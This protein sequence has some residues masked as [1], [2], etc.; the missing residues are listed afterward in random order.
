MSPQVITGPVEPEQPETFQ[1]ESSQLENSQPENSQVVQP[2]NRSMDE[3][4]QLQTELL[5]VTVVAAGLIFVSVWLFYSLNT[6]LNYLLGACGG[7]VYLK[8][9]ARNVERLGSENQKTG[10][11]H[12]A[13]FVG[14][15]IVATQWKSLHVLP[16]FL[17]FLTYKVSLL[18]YM[19]RILLP[20]QQDVESG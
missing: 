9:L 11:S 3:Y 7:V 2:S 8:L 19:F 1:P 12:L 13:I 10:K 18:F 5:V 16:V 4:Y 14:L 6:A 17:G 20:R 15:I